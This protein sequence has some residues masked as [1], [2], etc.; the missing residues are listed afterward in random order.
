MCS[1]VCFV[2]E[3]LQVG[4]EVRL[5]IQ[6]SEG[7]RVWFAMETLAGSRA[8]VEIIAPDADESLAPTGTAF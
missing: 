3:S 4:D 2:G 6:K 5:E 1:F 8:V 7:N